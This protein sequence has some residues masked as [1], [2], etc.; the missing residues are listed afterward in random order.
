MGE[1]RTPEGID[2][3]E[4]LFEVWQAKWLFLGVII[5]S[6]ALAG[7]YGRMAEIGTEAVEITTP[8]EKQ[9]TAVF[10]VRINPVFEPFRRS[11]GEL[12][13]DLKSRLG[14]VDGK[15]IIDES[16]LA[17]NIV[18]PDY[19][20]ATKLFTHSGFIYLSLENG[21]LILAEQIMDAFNVAAESQFKQT[22]SQVSAGINSINGMIGNVAPI[23]EEIL[24]K[25]YIHRTNFLDLPEVIDGSH[26]FFIFGPVYETQQTEITAPVRKTAILKLLTL[27]AIIGFVLA[28]IVIMFRIALRRNLPGGIAVP[29]I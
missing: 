14:K 23:S 8:V 26:R 10:P 13:I 1:A 21:S 7:L 27:G 25:E 6:V 12:W 16:E 24:I 19:T 9:F 17:E 29:R 15:E 5:V 20:Y 11:A 3:F 2:F 18:R 22:L 4:F 28:C